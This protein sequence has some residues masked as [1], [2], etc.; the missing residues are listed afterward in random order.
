MSWAGDVARLMSRLLFNSGALCESF[1]LATAEHHR[2]GEIAEYYTEIIGLKYVPASTE[3]YLKIQGGRNYFGYQLY[4]DRLFDRII[5][6]SKV[7]GVTGL[8][9]EN[10]MT[11][12]NGLEKELTALPRD[13]V[14]NPAAEVWDRMDAYLKKQDM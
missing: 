5:D 8:K 2:W 10:F 3:D 1:T 7:L 14:W 6:N 13:V 11:L 9:Q 4:Y 12:R